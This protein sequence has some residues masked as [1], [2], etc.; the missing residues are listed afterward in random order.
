MDTALD[1]GH[2]KILA[3]SS[4]HQMLPVNL[5]GQYADTWRG[6]EVSLWR[7]DI[8]GMH[9]TMYVCLTQGAYRASCP[10]AGSQGL[11]R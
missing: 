11:W 2:P 9:F 1:F 3:Q 4:A 6:V 5:D 8:I 10:S 7:Q